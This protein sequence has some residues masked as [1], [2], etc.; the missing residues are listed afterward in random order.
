MTEIE[1]DISEAREILAKSFAKPF[2]I[3]WAWEILQ[4]Q[5][6]KNDE[7]RC[8]QILL[9]AKF[10]EGLNLPTHQKDGLPTTPNKHS[11]VVGYDIREHQ[12]VCVKDVKK[13]AIEKKLDWLPATASTPNNIDG[14]AKLWLVADPRDPEPK[15]DWHT[16]ARFF[17]RKVLEDKPLLIHNRKK[18]AEEVAKLLA[19]AG[20]KPRAKKS[21][22]YQVNTILRAFENIT[23]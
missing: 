21:T 23:F 12:Y 8:T 13:F 4:K 14:A 7:E 22:R 1:L 9:R 6:Y 11:T 5:S 3:A 20:I 2:D 15:L 10:I 19:G 18:V 16:P 17:A